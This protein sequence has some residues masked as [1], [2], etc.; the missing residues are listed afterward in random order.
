VKINNEI[1]TSS[2]QLETFRL[3]RD[4]ENFLEV[5]VSLE[6]TRKA[7]LDEDRDTESRKLLFERPDGAGEEETIPHRAQTY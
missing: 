1:K 6:A 4:R 3:F 5:R 2:Q 7:R